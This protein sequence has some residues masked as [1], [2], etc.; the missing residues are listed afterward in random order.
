MPIRPTDAMTCA[1]EYPSIVY[2]Q[3][4]KKLYPDVPVVLGGIEAS[5]RRLTHYDYWEEK[6]RPSILVESGADLLIYGMGEKP[7]TELSERLLEVEREVHAG[8]LP[9]D[10]PQTAYLI[11]QKE[12]AALPENPN[13]QGDLT[14]Y[15][16]EECLERGERGIRADEDCP[17]VHRAVHRESPPEYRLLQGRHL[18]D[19]RFA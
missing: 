12:V 2:T 10:I 3:I 5:L 9:H 4:L 18:H 6:L 15:P 14:L 1:R 16:H 8:D 19:E 17:S 7:L 11:S 13:G